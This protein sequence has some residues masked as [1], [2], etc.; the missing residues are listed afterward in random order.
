MTTQWKLVWLPSVGKVELHKKLET[1]L[2]QSRDPSRIYG[3]PEEGGSLVSIALC[4]FLYYS[5]Q[6][7][8]LAASDTKEG[9]PSRKCLG[10]EPSSSGATLA[11]NESPLSSVLRRS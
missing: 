5:H 2:G 8:T 10:F 11:Q 9:D 3:D 7:D 6:L 1:F 4:V